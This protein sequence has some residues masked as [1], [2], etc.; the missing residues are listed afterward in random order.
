MNKA[1]VPLHIHNVATAL[2]TSTSSSWFS[3]SVVWA[4][5]DSVYLSS[6][7]NTIST[8]IILISVERESRVD[9]IGEATAVQTRVQEV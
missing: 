3:P 6:C 4:Q 2:L 9:G 1:F 7:V 8:I 5:R